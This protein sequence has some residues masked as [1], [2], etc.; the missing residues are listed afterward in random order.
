LVVRVVVDDVQRV[1]NLAGRFDRV[2]GA[3]PM[4]GFLA[5]L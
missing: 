1:A 5:G 4:E 3:D 2:K